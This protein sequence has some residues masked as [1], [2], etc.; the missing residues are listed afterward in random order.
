[1]GR[2]IPYAKPALD[3]L[4]HSRA[5][6]QVVRETGCPR[7]GQQ[8]LDQFL[9]LRRIELWPLA[10][11]GLGPQGF[12]TSLAHRDSPTSNTGLR[13]SNRRGHFRHRITL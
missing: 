4:R 11:L 2:M 3:Y 10:R 12:Q 8:D 1:M 13:G 6:P 5:S 9:V 7:S